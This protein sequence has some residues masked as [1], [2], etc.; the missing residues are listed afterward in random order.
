VITLPR[1]ARR[2]MKV[3]AVFEN[4]IP[5]PI[6]AGDV[7]GTLRITRV[8]PIAQVKSHANIDELKKRHTELE[9]TYWEHL[10]QWTDF[11]AQLS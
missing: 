11:V 10:R 7:I 4:P 6:R 2:D 9:A 1:R 8:D 5:A 3:A